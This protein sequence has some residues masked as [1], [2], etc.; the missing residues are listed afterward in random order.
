MAQFADIFDV[1]FFVVNNET[2][3]AFT[4][5]VFKGGAN[6][7][8]NESFNNTSP[9][10]LTTL[11]T[12]YEMLP[13]ALLGT[14][15]LSSV[16]TIYSDGSVVS[17]E[18]GF[19]D[20]C[21]E[22]DY[23]FV[24][25]GGLD[26]L[27]MLGKIASKESSTEVILES[28]PANIVYSGILANNEDRNI[29]HLHKNSPGLPFKA[30]SSFYMVIKNPD[31]DDVDNLGLHN[32]IPYID[33]TQTAPSSDVFAYG[34]TQTGNN[35]LNLTYFSIVYISAI[36][37]A[38]NGLTSSNIVYGSGSIPCT[39]SPISTLSQQL[40]TPLTGTVSQEDIP[41]WSVYLVNPY[42]T[43]TSLLPKNT[44]YRVEI[45][46]NIPVRKLQISGTLPE[47]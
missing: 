17:S 28:P 33:Y 16:A 27:L 26:S 25:D 23:L 47:A 39:I 31:Y 42:G 9:V 5:N 29:Y 11:S 19:F 21:A 12:N 24:D 32:A 2:T 10:D 46:S 7:F 43:A 15:E 18:S 13:P 20:T 3:A 4:N 14:G 41:Y 45:A 37:N 44:S 8:P 34:G 40:A 22:G 6:A 30:N 36:N 1:K 38:T 35:T